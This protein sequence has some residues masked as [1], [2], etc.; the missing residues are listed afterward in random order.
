MRTIV[1]ALSALSLMLALGASAAAQDRDPAP[2]A[3][4]TFGDDDVLGTRVDPTTEVLLVRQPGQR[5]S[6]VRP[7]L[8]FVPELLES[9]ER[10]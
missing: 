7:R 2:D 4:Y 9:I 8:H 5:E 3:T 1:T 6:L 10:L